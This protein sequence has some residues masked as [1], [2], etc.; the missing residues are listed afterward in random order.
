MKTISI[1]SDFACPYCYIGE[2][3]LKNAIKEL[4]IGNEIRIAYRSFE[5]NPQ[6]PI[7][8][9][10]DIAQL[11]ASKY[12]LTA[13]EAKSKIA[14]IDK[15]GHEIGI[16]MRYGKAQSTNTFDAHKLMKFAEAE[17]EPVIVEALNEALFKAYFTDNKLLSDRK[18]LVDLAES[19]GM[20]PVQA[21]EVV[22]SD[23]YNNDVRYDEQ[24]ATSMGVH[25]VPYLVFDGEFA[26]PGAVSTEDFKTA[27]HDLLSKVKEKPEGMKGVS[28]DENGCNVR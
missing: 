10:Q 23:L 7:K 15:L 22:D 5:L 28:C 25:G 12:G 20:D 17:Y 19:V 13:Q 3:R 1:W 24:E 14:E 6:A 9:N 11:L 4:G 8:S 16:E 26:I 27:L 21:K 2:R 18:L